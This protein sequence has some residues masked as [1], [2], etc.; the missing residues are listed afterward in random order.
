LNA[1]NKLKE[2]YDQLKPS[3]E[4]NR[5]LDEKL[6]L[7]RVPSHLKR[8]FARDKQYV[9]TYPKRF[10]LKKS[11]TR[12]RASLTATAPMKISPAKVNFK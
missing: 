3:A 1:V 4:Y 12:Y 10:K 11:F 9:K 6:P 7:N 5:D 8:K 2:V